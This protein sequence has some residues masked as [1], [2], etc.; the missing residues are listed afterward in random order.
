MKPW[1]G[2]GDGDGYAGPGHPRPLDEWLP[3]SPSSNRRRLLY[4]REEHVRANASGCGNPMPKLVRRD[5]ER[6]QG[7]V[8]MGMDDTNVVRRSRLRCRLPRPMI[9][10]VGF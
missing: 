9:N 7:A 6:F 2:V 5:A 8:G 1:V 4:R 3:Y 10:M